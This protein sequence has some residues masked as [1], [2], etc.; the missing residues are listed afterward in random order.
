MGKGVDAEGGLLDEE[1]SENTGVDEAA[2]PVTPTQTSNNSRNNE[3]HN[4]NNPEVVLVLPDDNGVL[5]QVGN[6]GTANALGI[7]LHDHPANVRVQETLADR[8]GVLVG[9][10]VAVMSPVIARPP[11][12][13]TLNCTTTGGS[14]ENLQRRRRG[15]RAVGPKTVIPRRYSQTGVKVVEDGPDER[16]GLEGSLCRLVKTDGRNNE[17]EGDI[18][19]VDVLIPVAQSDGL[20]SKVSICNSLEPHNMLEMR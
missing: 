19:P 16:L 11:S 13:G 7:L 6:V 2:L 10:G 14:K 17:N 12:D 15:V 3:T 1:D 8:V 18:E 20:N 9:V 4:G 5:V